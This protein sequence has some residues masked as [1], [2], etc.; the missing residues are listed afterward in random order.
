MIDSSL[1]Y[2]FVLSQL[3]IFFKMKNLPVILTANL[4]K[5]EFYFSGQKFTLNFLI[6]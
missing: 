2:H 3:M 4:L 1:C 5:S 6:D